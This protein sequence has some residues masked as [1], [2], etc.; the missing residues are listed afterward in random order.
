MSLWPLFASG[1]CTL[2]AQ[3]SQTCRHITNINTVMMTIFNSPKVISE[4]YCDQM[5]SKCKFSIICLFR[6]TSERAN[7]RA[8]E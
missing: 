5:I 1:Q 2:L 4:S 3:H 6:I 7:E 8:N